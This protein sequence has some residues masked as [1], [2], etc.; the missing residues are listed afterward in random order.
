MQITPISTPTHEQLV[1]VTAELRKLVGERMEAVRAAGDDLLDPRL[2]H[3]LDVHL[4]QHLERHL[5]TAAA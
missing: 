5:V 3:P 2:V 1:K 4:R